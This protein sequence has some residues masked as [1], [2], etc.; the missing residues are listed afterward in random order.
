MASDLISVASV[1][2]ASIKPPK[3]GVLEIF[4]AG[5]H[6]DVQLWGEWCIQGGQGRSALFPHTLVSAPLPPAVPE[7]YPFI[8]NLV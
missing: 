1:I 7:F 3:E 6:V 4:W 2:K 8:I 5:E